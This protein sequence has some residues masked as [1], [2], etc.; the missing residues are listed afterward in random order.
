[1]ARSASLSSNESKVPSSKAGL[2]GVERI[3]RQPRIQIAEIAEIAEQEAGIVRRSQSSMPT[4]VSAPIRG[5]IE[6]GECAY[7][8]FQL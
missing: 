8:Y 1:M 4:S 6:H 2:S 5:A 7:R 3:A